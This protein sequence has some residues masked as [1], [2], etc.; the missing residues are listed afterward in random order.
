MNLLIVDTTLLQWP[1]ALSTKFVAGKIVPAYRLCCVLQGPDPEYFQ[2]VVGPKTPSK[3]DG[4]HPTV[5]NSK[6]ENEGRN[7]P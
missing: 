4:P 2:M 5:I 1:E 7:A 3:E 6:L